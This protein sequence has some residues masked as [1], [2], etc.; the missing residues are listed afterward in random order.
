MELE[1]GEI[2]ELDVIILATGFKLNCNFLES[3]LK[4]KIFAD[5]GDLRLHRVILPPSVHTIGFVGYQSTLS[6]A[7]NSELS[8][9]W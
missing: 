7:M 8:I 9:K 4:S 6:H 5:N 3:D 2:L 1:N